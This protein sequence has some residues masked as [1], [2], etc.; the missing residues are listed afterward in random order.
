MRHSSRQGFL[1]TSHRQNMNLPTFQPSNSLSPVAER[2][3]HLALRSLKQI[4]IRRAAER[5]PDPNAQAAAEL[6]QAAQ[7]VAT[8]HPPLGAELAQLLL[9]HAS[10]L[11]PGGNDDSASF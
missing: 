1:D 7:D 10:R 8:Q 5:Q 2:E 3:Y 9:Q 11:A 4:L 6:R